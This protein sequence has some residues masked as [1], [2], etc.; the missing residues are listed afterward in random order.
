ML[1]TGSHEYISG[2]LVTELNWEIRKQQLPSTSGFESIIQ[3]SKA[4]V[5][6]D[7]RR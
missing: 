6:E 3:W 5:H 1:P 2:F 4:L 7:F